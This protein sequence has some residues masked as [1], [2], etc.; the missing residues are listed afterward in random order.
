MSRKEKSR[1]VKLHRCTVSNRSSQ[2][3]AVLP[4]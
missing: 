3:G 4:F 2:P 1:A